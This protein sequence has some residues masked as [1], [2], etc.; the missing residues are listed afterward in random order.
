M[1]IEKVFL[2]PV[3]NRIRRIKPIHAPCNLTPE[4]IDSIQPVITKLMNGLEVKEKCYILR[5][6]IKDHFK[7]NRKYHA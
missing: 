2:G 7:H 4:E 6:C 1:N 3:N 5:T